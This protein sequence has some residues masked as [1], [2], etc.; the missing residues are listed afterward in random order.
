MKDMWRCAAWAGVR[1]SK[2]EGTERPCNINMQRAK[3]VQGGGEEGTDF[4]GKRKNGQI[5]ICP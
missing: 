5:F 2:D 3:R 4:E 1:M